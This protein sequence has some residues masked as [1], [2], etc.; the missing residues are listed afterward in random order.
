LLHGVLKVLKDGSGNT[1]N[2][3]RTYIIIRRN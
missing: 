2:N 1:Q 3:L